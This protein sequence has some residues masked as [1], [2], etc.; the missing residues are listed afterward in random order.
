M[1]N[2]EKTYLRKINKEDTSNIIRWRNSS[3]VKKYFF[4][5]D[6]LTKEQHYWWLENKVNTGEVAQFIIVDKETNS[7][8]GTVF[9]KDIDKKNMKAEYGIFIGDEKAR[10]KG[11]GTEAAKL[12]CSYGFKDLCLHRIFLRVFA[13][14]TQAKNSYIKAGFKEEAVLRDDVCINNKFY[15]VIIMGKVN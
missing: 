2:G 12:I 3:N 8:V 15:D 13:G 10:G 9:L 5:Q 7:D 6:D 4:I 1:I 14:N 11:I